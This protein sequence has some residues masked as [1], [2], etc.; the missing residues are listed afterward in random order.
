[1]DIRIQVTN[2]HIR[3]GRRNEPRS[4]P[5]ALAFRDAGYDVSVAS[6]LHW[7][8]YAACA[9]LTKPTKAIQEFVNAFDKKLVVKPREFRV[10]VSKS[11]AE[12]ARYH[13]EDDL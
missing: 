13:H 7:G 10:R 2:E 12:G 6:E 1:M 11:V 8:H 3:N 4:C 9:G 5:V